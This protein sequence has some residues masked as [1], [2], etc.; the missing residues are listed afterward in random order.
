MHIPVAHIEAGL[1][2]FDKEMPEELNRVMTDHISKYLFA[3]TEN[4]AELLRKEGLVEGVSITGN[5]IVDAVM[6]NKELADDK[7]LSGLGEY[8]LLTLHRA[9]NVDKREVLEGIIE[10][11]K[12]SIE[13][14]GKIVWPMHPRTKARLEKFGIT[15][16]ED[17]VVMEPLGYL[18]FLTLE[19]NAK[20]ILTDSGGLQEEACILGVPCVTIRTTTE[21]PE[22]IEVG[23]NVLA[24]VSSD[25]I[26]EG[27]KKMLK[28]ERNWKSPFGD[29]KAAERILDTILA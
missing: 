5:T 16:P 29:G 11:L 23:S 20:L 12:R 10:G 15:L 18:D 7:I 4:G 25:G 13:I 2:S 27:V 22:T 21:R 26:I 17:I 3:P 28:S 14:I 8:S 19:A 6:R 1:R 24:G 9:E